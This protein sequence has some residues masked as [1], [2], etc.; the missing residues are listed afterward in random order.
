M[1]YNNSGKYIN[2]VYTS[3]NGYVSGLVCPKGGR[4]YDPNY[5]SPIF[6]D[7]IDVE[8]GEEFKL[9]TQDIAPDILPYYA[10]SNYGRIEN[11]FTR[12]LIKVNY[13][14]NG[15]P[16]VCLAADNCKFGQKKYSLHRL[17]L[18]AFNPVDN[19]DSLEVN[20][21]YCD[22]TKNYVNKIM[23]DGSIDSSIEWATPKENISHAIA[24][25]LRGKNKLTNEDVVNIREKY[26][27]GYTIKD[28]HNEYTFVS[29]NTIVDVCK[30]KTHQKS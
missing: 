9:L 15:Y 3:K 4:L 27:Q 21:I 22:K 2:G 11:I 7:P 29:Y 13:R 1:S 16:Y 26:S 18:K 8:K 14:P 6:F 24:N 23:E 25:N 20:H 30:N 19:M 12:Q 10:I 5:K 17:V 28:I